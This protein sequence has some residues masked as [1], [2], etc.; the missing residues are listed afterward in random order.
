MF[1]FQKET[2]TERKGENNLHLLMIGDVQLSEWSASH[3]VQLGL[4][5][6][7]LIKYTI[8]RSARLLSWSSLLRARVTVFIFPFSSP[9]FFHA[10]LSLLGLRTRAGGGEGTRRAM[11]GGRG[12]EGSRVEGQKGCHWLVLQSAHG[13]ERRLGWPVIR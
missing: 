2:E 5:P 13:R 6:V 9:C 1:F 11:P 7:E 10:L 4:F 3:S 8:P 12:M